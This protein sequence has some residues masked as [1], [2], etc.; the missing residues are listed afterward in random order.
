MIK[1]LN[2]YIDFDT[3]VDTRLSLLS[4]F[5]SELSE[6]LINNGKY[7]ERKLDEFGY[8]PQ[9]IFEYIYKHRTKHILNGVKR[10]ALYEYLKN[11]IYIEVAEQSANNF[12]TMVKLVVNTY[13]YKFTQDEQNI[14]NNM[15][16]KTFDQSNMTIDFKYIE[17]TKVTPY[18]ILENN[19]NIMVMYDFIEWVD[20]QLQNGKMVDKHTLPSV[21]FLVPKLTKNITIFSTN[22]EADSLYEH[23]EEM[24]KLRLTVSFLP[25]SVFSIE[26]IKK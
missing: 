3:L 22:S 13:P 23:F 15:L 4:A 8:L 19:I 18:Y 16:H 26:K 7:F 11:Y 25:P 2:I 12:L 9:N 1:N 17:K 6:E 5:D 14:F 24:L 21:L 10:T 20:L